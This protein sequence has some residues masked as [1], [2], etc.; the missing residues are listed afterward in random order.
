MRS[1][2]A[3]GPIALVDTRVAAYRTLLIRS[4]GPGPTV[5][6]SAP[7]ASGMTRRDAPKASVF[8]AKAFTRPLT[9]TTLGISADFDGSDSAHDSPI[10]N[11]KTKMCQVSTRP[12]ISTVAKLVVNRNWYT[13]EAIRSLRRSHVSARTPPMGPAIKKGSE[14]RPRTRL[15]SNGEWVRS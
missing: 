6:T 14:S 3:W 2:G 12:R 10:A 7:P 8:R 13:V 11:T 15:V 4:V 5:T 9:G 1:R